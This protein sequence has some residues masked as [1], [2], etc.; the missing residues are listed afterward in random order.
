MMQSAFKQGIGIA[1]GAL[2]ALAAIAVIIG[3]CVIGYGYITTDHTRLALVKDVRANCDEVMASS[4]YPPVGASAFA[5]L[6]FYEKRKKD[7][8]ACG[9][10]QMKL[11]MH[12]AGVDVSDL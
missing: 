6:D 7:L 1:L 10:A 8:A 4:A 3:V 9:A 2:V 12:D 11:Q 5:E